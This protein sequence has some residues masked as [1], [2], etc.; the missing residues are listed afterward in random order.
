M[1]NMTSKLWENISELLQNLEK[2]RKG[3]PNSP[4]PRLSLESILKQI[5]NS[6]TLTYEAF[7]LL[8]K[9]INA[10]ANEYGELT[11]SLQYRRPDEIWER[12]ADAVILRIHQHLRE[13]EN[14]EFAA[15]QALP[16]PS[17]VISQPHPQHESRQVMN[18]HLA[19]RE[20]NLALLKQF[21]TD[22][23]ATFIFNQAD[24][25]SI[26]PLQLFFRCGNPETMRFLT[27]KYESNM[28]SVITGEDQKT[29]FRLLKKICKLPFTTDELKPILNMTAAFIHATDPNE[30]AQ[31]REQL[32]QRLHQ[33]IPQTQHKQAFFEKNSQ[34]RLSEID[35]IMKK[36]EGDNPHLNHDAR[37]LKGK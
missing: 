22:K 25:Y 37:P 9:Q 3:I 2:A 21:I 29:C 34:T 10:L 24:E 23:H 6:Q 17:R 32:M 13:I 12:N 7:K 28:L 30:K 20:G 27:T 19:I 26:T 36:V 4:A 5:D 18:C 16:L 8:S 33:E 11:A 31:L 1:P 35:S 15:L 14:Q